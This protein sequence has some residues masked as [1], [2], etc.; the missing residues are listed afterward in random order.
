MTAVGFHCLCGMQGF[1]EAPGTSRLGRFA[2]TQSSAKLTTPQ[3]SNLAT[4]FL[5]RWGER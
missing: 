4:H 3:A 2:M 5:E 1:L